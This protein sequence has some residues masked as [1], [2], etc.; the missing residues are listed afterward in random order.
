MVDREVWRKVERQKIPNDR[1][2]IGYKWV[3][4]IIRYGT[5]RVRLVTLWYIQIPA[6]DYT[7]NFAPGAHD[8]SFRITLARMIVEKLDSIV[9][10]VE[11]A[12]LY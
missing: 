7:C 2:L 1:R 10:D 6:V 4:K 8:V 3:F 12:Y 11:T 5:Y 9:M